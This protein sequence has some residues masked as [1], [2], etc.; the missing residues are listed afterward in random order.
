M[1]PLEPIFVTKLFPKLDSELIALLK[2]LS[3]EDWHKPTVCAEW[4]VKDIVAHLLDGNFRTLSTKR[5]GYF[6]MKP[7]GI[8]SYQGLVEFLNRINAEWV[9]AAKRLSPQVLIWLLEETR[10]DVYKIINAL[11]PHDVALH[12]VAWAGEDVSEN[13]FDIAR[14]YT[15]RWHHQQ[16]I[17]LAVDKPGVMTR[18]FYFPVL[19]A[20]IR[21]L[22]HTYRDVSAGEKTLLKF[23]IAGEAGGTW[24]L[25]RENGRW[26]LGTNAEGAPASEV[27]ITDAIA[28]RLFTKGIAKEEARKQITIT[29]DENLGSVILNMTSVMA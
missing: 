12:S 23:Y 20:F 18:E 7:E 14:G 9:T 21:A 4:N 5:D 25:L 6:G 26:I 8:D 22:P 28:W 13:W 24:F 17:R 11:D 15:E 19:D 27:T 2:N 16:Q 29:G 3:D 1:K 10:D